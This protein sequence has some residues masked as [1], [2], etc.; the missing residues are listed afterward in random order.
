MNAQYLQSC[1]H[2]QWI[3]FADIVCI[4]T[5]CDFNRCDERTASRHYTA[6][7]RTCKICI[8]SDEFCPVQHVIHGFADE[9]IVVICGFPDDY[10]VRIN[11]VISNVCIVQCIEKSGFSDDICAAARTLMA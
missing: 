8:C 2:H 9:A 1:S 11:I 3:G 5:C 7:G 6:F 4:F 10:I